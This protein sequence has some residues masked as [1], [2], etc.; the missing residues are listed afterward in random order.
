[1]NMKQ[2]TSTPYLEVDT[3]FMQPE[4]ESGEV[5]AREPAQ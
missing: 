4:V 2:L 5:M 3:G 1:M